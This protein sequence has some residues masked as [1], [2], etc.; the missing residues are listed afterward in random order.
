MPLYNES[1]FQDSAEQ[2]PMYA[3]SDFKDAL[4][5]PVD[6]TQSGADQDN[7]LY[8][9]W[10][11]LKGLANLGQ[12][13]QQGYENIASQIA[14]RLGPSYPKTAATLAGITSAIPQAIVPQTPMAV[15]LTPLMALGGAGK[16]AQA[17]EETQPLNNGALTYLAKNTQGVASDSYEF[18]KSNL[19]DVLKH[20]Q[21]TPQDTSV[22]AQQ[23]KDSVDGIVSGAKQ[24]YDDTLNSIAQ[25]PKYQGKTFNLATRFKNQIF[26]TA[27][28]FLYDDPATLGDSPEAKTFWNYAG[29][30]DQLRKAT[31]DQVIAYKQ[32][33]S[34][35]ADQYA[36]KPLGAA[37]AQLAAKISPS[38]SDSVPEI[39]DADRVYEQGMAVRDAMKPF[40]DVND[41]VG[42]I[43]S[44]FGS[45]YDT[46]KK[47]LINLATNISPDI[48][49]TVQAIRASVAA[50]SF[51]PALRGLPQTGYGAMLSKLAMGGL[52][53]ATALA[54]TGHPF[55]AAGAAGVAGAGAILSSPRA[56]LM[57]LQAMNYLRSP[58]VVPAINSIARTIPAAYN[59]LN[60]QASPNQDSTPQMPSG[61][62]RQISGL[63][64]PFKAG[65]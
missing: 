50:Q 28:D 10:N 27:R 37:F 46:N 5:Q 59:A 12:Q 9:G 4:S 55:L 25:N 29:K 43:R 26:T 14:G 62:Q 1:D 48:D 6:N 16:A 51:S 42:A 34:Q 24:Y 2:P 23:L 49:K 58:G 44:A 30:V 3:E 52:G 7:G 19:E 53:G 18:A 21:D 60:Y 39:Y 11:P 57:G 32:M 8:L 61:M 33:A 38:I 31:I 64:N 22:L 17:T 45:I 56:A 15:A 41:T 65:Q 40:T 47:Q 36:G 63:S 35:L 54:S 13:S 20:I